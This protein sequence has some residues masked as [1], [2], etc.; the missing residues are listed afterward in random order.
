MDLYGALFRSVL[1]PAWEAGLRGRPTLERLDWLLRTQYRPAAELLALQ[2]GALRR[3]VRHAVRHV[4]FYRERLAQAGVG[5]DEVR[6][7]GD[8]SRIPILDRE[9]AQEAG[10]ARQSTAPPRCDIQKSTS[11]TMGR[12]LVFGYDLGSEYWRQA[13]KLRGYGWAGYRPGD[14]ALH[15]WGARAWP[16]PSRKQRLKTAAD[17]ALRREHYLDCTSRDEAHLEAVVEAIRRERPQ[18]LVCFTQAGADLARYIN[19]TGVRDWDTIPVLCG[20][21][22]LFAA[23]RAALLAAFGDQ[24]YETYG[25][26]EVMLIG[27]ECEAHAGLHL[28][29]ENLIVEVVVRDGAMARPAQPGETGEVVLTDLHNYGMPFLRYANGDLAMAGPEGVCRCG[30]TLPRLGAVEGRVTETLRDAQGAPV[31]GLMFNV[32]FAGPLAATV[33]QFQVVQHADRSITLRVVPAGPGRFDERARR[34]ILVNCQQHLQGLLVRTELVEDIPVGPGGKRK[35]VV[36]ER[37]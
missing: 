21:E 33:R 18:V 2:A 4:P 20:A 13:V 29:A 36:V 27:A 19:Q 3:L 25:A 23:D 34:H 22:R 6:D 17:R 37:A 5:P 35:V 28:S 26:R 11:G 16:P 10:E 32:L 8:L 15:Y 24:V 30:R 9:E 12:P 7:V 31:S 14:R 1:W